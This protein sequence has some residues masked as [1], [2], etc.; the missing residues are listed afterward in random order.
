MYDL[1][2]IGGGAAGVFSAIAFKEKKPRSKVLILEKSSSLLTK[3]SLTGGGRCNLTNAC[4]EPRK[5]V[6]NYPRGSKELLGPLYS[7]SP[8]ETINWFE[9][10]GVA[11]KV[12]DN[13]KVFPVSDKSQ[14]IINCF[15][16]EIKK[17]EIEIFF[18]F[19]LKDILKNNNFFEIDHNG[20][21]IFTKNLILAT[22]NNLQ[23][24]DL[25]K[26]FGHTIQK[27]IPS[28][29]TFNSKTSYLKDLSGV[30]HNP[31]EVKIKD[32]AFS[33][34]GS[35]LITHFGFSGPVILSLSSFAAK[36]LN[37]KNYEAKISINWLSG[38]SQDEIFKRL[39]EL[40][41]N[42]PNNFLYLSNIFNLPRNLWGALLDSASQ[43]L[44]KK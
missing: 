24:Y 30:T 34:S 11:L 14:T 39:F 41:N 42:C 22:G 10:K 12:E 44:R 32:T 19:V 35:I 4:F 21:K 17:L 7:F 25:A 33:Q 20:R 29:F 6:L 15:L 38:I 13:G 31:V 37:E 27:P 36:Y 26:Q 8:R 40:K 2:I 43:N 28:L 18:D 16:T 23:G 3:L 5:L 1:I 9:S